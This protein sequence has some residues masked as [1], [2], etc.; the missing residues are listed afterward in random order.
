MDRGTPPP[1]KP[2]GNTGSAAP[3]A[4]TP[5][6]SPVPD[7]ATD[8]KPPAAPPADGKTFQRSEFVPV[9]G[10]ATVRE[11]PRTDVIQAGGTDRSTFPSQPPPSSAPGGSGEQLHPVPAPS[12]GG[13]PP[14]PTGSQP[15]LKTEP[16]RY[17][18]SANFQRV[19]TAAP[20][21]ERYAVTV[22]Q[23]RAGDTWDKISSHEYGT[24]RCAEA[25]R[26]FNR[27][28][29]QTSDQL[30][31]HGQLVPGDRIYLPPLKVLEDKHRAL[32]R[33]YEQPAARTPA[34]TTPVAPP[35][36]TPSTPA[37]AV[38]PPF[39]PPAGGGSPLP[40]PPDSS[41]PPPSGGTVPAPPPDSGSTGTVPPPPPGGSGP[42]PLPSPGGSGS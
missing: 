9:P 20:R 3:G 38:P 42:P 10:S 22:Y 13:S 8:P 29:P 34:A 25:L 40:P 24:E 17:N 26:E 5:P 31:Q 19:S 4:H 7:R 39:T 35:A 37:P 21:T 33:P 15:K 18:P 6:S 1:V 28:Y 23:V 36:S 16:I 14:P 27:Q 32:I 12:P 30:K 41:A 2:E 11:L